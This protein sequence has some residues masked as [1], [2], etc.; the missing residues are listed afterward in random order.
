MGRDNNRDGLSPIST[1]HLLSERRSPLLNL[2][3]SPHPSTFSS[4]PSPRLPSPTWSPPARSE[5][6]S[7]FMGSIDRGRNENP[8]QHQQLLQPYNEKPTEAHAGAWTNTPSKEAGVLCRIQ[9]FLTCC[10]RPRSKKQAHSMRQE[11]ETVAIEAQ[12]WTEL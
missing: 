9:K 7:P 6:H 10:L 3:T 5:I 12:H 11:G 8:W 1:H 2:P 4:L